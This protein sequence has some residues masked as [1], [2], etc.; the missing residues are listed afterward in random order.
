MTSIRC[1]VCSEIIAGEGTGVD[2]ALRDHLA[3]GHNMAD[4]CMSPEK[5]YRDPP[6]PREGY[7]GVLCPI[8]ADYIVAPEGGFLSEGL[9]AH[10][11]RV[12]GIRPASLLERLRR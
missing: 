8:C 7:E 9:R 10:F 12:H 1:P 3:D 4:L 6:A 5:L 2:H 11:G